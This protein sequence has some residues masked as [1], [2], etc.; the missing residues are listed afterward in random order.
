MRYTQEC[1][2]AHSSSAIPDVPA[3]GAQR[4]A[5]APIRTHVH[6]PNVNAV[7]LYK[8]IAA[9]VNSTLSLV[10]EY[11]QQGH[12]IPHDLRT[13]IIFD[14]IEPDGS[15]AVVSGRH[16][17][18][19]DYGALFSR[20]YD[21]IP[22]QPTFVELFEYIAER[23]LASV[24]LADAGG[25]FIR[26]PREAQRLLADKYLRPIVTH[27]LAEGASAPVSNDFLRPIFRELEHYL[28]SDAFEVTFWTPLANFRCSVGEARLSEDLLL[29][30]LTEDERK[31]LWRRQ[32]EGAVSPGD[33]VRTT[34]A[35]ETRYP[36]SKYG[37]VTSSAAQSRFQH[38]MTAMRLLKP[39]TVTSY[40]T[41]YREST[42]SL[43]LRRS[44]GSWRDRPPSPGPQYELDASDIDGVRGLYLVL[45]ERPPAEAVA[46]A[47]DRFN[48]GIE[49]GKY[50]DR[51]LDYW[52][53]LE[54]LFSP[55]DRQELKYR[56]RLRTAHFIGSTPDEREEAY[57]RLGASYDTRSAVIHGRKPTADL[58]SVCED[59]EG[60]L[61]TA[62]R[63]IVLSPQPFDAESLDGL[64]ARGSPR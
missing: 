8:R 41:V 22:S 19:P 5:R 25:N 18:A 12:E 4:G 38:C 32:D 56:L 24:L 26:D 58:R 34:F 51:L 27:C 35:L 28:S 46:L 37:G 39:G 13:D 3:P 47:V 15:V 29:R 57:H 11:L 50:E 42:A 30:Q 16:V 60:I 52:I 2:E 45:T 36:V 64:I 44:G 10:A 23:P 63:R 33:A 61:R 20:L 54:G 43:F 59:T 17:F 1:N 40:L 62:L 9:S 31:D 21:H 53:A 14:R 6:C 7:D 48:Q 49:R 55:T